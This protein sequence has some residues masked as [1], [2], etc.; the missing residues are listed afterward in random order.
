VCKYSC[1]ICG[2]CRTELCKY[3]LIYGQKLGEGSG[4]ALNKRQPKVS[5]PNVFNYFGETLMQMY[6]SISN[7]PKGS[8]LMIFYQEH[9]IEIMQI[10]K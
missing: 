8:A 6:H 2:A 10:G 3:D 9:P 4:W 7:N 5:S 1:V